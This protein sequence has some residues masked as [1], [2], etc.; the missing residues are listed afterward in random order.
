MLTHPV[1]A[2]FICI[3][4]PCYVSGN[5]GKEKNLYKW[6]VAPVLGF[7]LKSVLFNYGVYIFSYISEDKRS[8]AALLF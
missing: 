7:N 8:L 4:I 2:C 3:K 5:Q 6:D 1:F